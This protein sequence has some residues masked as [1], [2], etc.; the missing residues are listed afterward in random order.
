MRAVVRHVIPVVAGREPH[1]A[2]GLTCGRVERLAENSGEDVVTKHEFLVPVVCL[3]HLRIVIVK[4]AAD[5]D[6]S[7]V[8]LTRERI[9]IW[10]ESIAQPDCRLM[11]S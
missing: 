2:L 7:V 8:R 6:S 9:D 4:R 10:R 3:L 5:A 1:S 11:Y